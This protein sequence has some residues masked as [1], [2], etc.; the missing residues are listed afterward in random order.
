MGYPMKTEHAGPKRGKGAYWGPKHE[1][2]RK[3]SR[4]RRESWRREIR[5]ET[6]RSTKL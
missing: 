3:S 6:G 5:A 2:K 1:A 4:K